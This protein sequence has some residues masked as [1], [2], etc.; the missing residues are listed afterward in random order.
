[1]EIQT[2]VPDSQ[3]QQTIIKSELEASMSIARL[4]PRS[5]GQF[6][7]R[8]LDTVSISEGVA[9]ECLYSL[10]R[11][12]KRIEGPSIRMAEIIQSCWTNCQSGARAISEE[13][14]FVVAQGAFRDLENNTIV[15]MDVRRRITDKNGSRFNDDMVNV[16]ANAACSI[17]RRN[18]ILGAIP[19]A[20]WS[21]A[22]H[23]ARYIVIGD[24]TT[25]GARRD[26]LVEQFGLW[27]VSLDQILAVLGKQTIEDV[28]SDDL[29]TM[30]AVHTQIKNGESK[31]DEIF[32]PIDVRSKLSVSDAIAQAAKATTSKSD[33]EKSQTFDEELKDHADKIVK[34]TGEMLG[35][36]AA[37]EVEKPKEI[38]GKP[39]EALAMIGIE[40]P[41]SQVTITCFLLGLKSVS[42]V[43]NI[44]K[45]MQKKLNEQLQ[46]MSSYFGANAVV[47]DFLDWAIEAYEKLNSRTALEKAIDAYD[48]H[49][50][51]ASEGE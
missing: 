7:K 36:L 50:A 49:E 16:T 4:N 20:L 15:T 17:A 27:N 47:L 12:G 38:K 5:V 30:I 51:Q 26:K 19:R 23:K 3:V 39:S 25:L 13:E 48:A 32:T 37:D 40:E 28:D 18:A 46:T 10:P 2:F 22:Y 1:M 42:N 33:Q 29:V 43:D 44:A 11:G 41:E 45:A 34:E 31:I 8:L 9:A 21:D 14:K 6:R 35:E 24:V